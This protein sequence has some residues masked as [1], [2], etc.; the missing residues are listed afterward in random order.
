MIELLRTNDIVL[1]SFVEAALKA[2]GIGCVILDGAM[3]V[4]EGSSLA[5]PRRLMV[6]VGD[7][8]RAKAIWDDVRGAYPY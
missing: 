7:G 3:S 4:T 8:G 5:I 1:L 6:Q 2:E